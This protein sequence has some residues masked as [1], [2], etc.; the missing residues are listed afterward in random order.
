MKVNLFLIKKILEKK[1]SNNFIN[2]DYSNYYE[3]NDMRLNTDR[4]NKGSNVKIELI[5]N[6]QNKTI[7]PDRIYFYQHALNNYFDLKNIK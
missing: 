2:Y 1:P 6:D 4:Y 3:Y 5:K 7:N